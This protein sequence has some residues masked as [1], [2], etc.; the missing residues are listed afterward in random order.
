M[1][2]S[3]KTLVLGASTNTGRYSNLATRRLLEEGHQA[4]P[5]GRKPGQISG[6]DILLGKP[7]LKNIHTVT[8]YLNPKN[9]VS[10]YAYILG[11]H[12][13]RIIFNP[14]SENPELEAKAKANGIDVEKA[15]TLV[16]LSTRMYVDKSEME[17]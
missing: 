12:P 15:C 9:Q 7:E 8:M 1:K 5:L 11:L 14:G 16:L 13:K 10:M 4:I 17:V 3:I 6:V 2:E